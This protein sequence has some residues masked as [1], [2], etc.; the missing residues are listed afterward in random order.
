MKQIKEYPKYFVTEDGKV[1]SAKG[2]KGKWL[3]LLKNGDYLKVIFSVKNN[4]KSFLTHRLVAEAYIPNPDNKPF[5]NHKN[6]IPTDNRVENL[7]WVTAQENTQH[8]WETGLC[9]KFT[10][11][12]EQRKKISLSNKG[13]KKQK[14]SQEHIK[15]RIESRL[16]TVRKK[17]LLH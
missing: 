2:K 11:T 6:G 15:K 13:K 4:K 12:E 3:S 8:A 7:E 10:L 1:W 16:E 5:V 17:H 9:K 14:Q